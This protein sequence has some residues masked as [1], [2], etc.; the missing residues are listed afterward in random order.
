MQRSVIE[1]DKKGGNLRRT[2]ICCSAKAD[3]GFGQSEKLHISLKSFVAKSSPTCG[4]DTKHD[5]RRMLSELHKPFFV[6]EG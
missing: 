5:N 3:G 2:P 4:L 1:R 6:L